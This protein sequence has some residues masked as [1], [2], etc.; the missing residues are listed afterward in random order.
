[1]EYLDD[2]HFT[3]SYHPGKTNVVAD[4]LSRKSRGMMAK[5]SVKEWDMVK[6]LNEFRIQV[7]SQDTKAYLS[8]QK[9]I[10]KLTNEVMEAQKHDQEVAYIKGRLE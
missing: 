10:P 3:L 7:E 9:V 6:T 5:I 4:A 2:F 1:M 8:A